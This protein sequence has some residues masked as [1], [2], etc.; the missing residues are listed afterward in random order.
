MSRR[1]PRFL[2]PFNLSEAD[3]RFFTEKGRLERALAVRSLLRH[4]FHPGSR[5]PGS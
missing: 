2:D 4:V 3:L 5:D 1:D